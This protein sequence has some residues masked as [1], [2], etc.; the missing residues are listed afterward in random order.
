MKDKTYSYRITDKLYS[1]RITDE[2]SITYL[3]SE[4]LL[5]EYECA[6]EGK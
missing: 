5:E 4:S 3:V 1:Y 2:I 6:L